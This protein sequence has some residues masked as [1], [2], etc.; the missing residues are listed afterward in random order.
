VRIAY[1]RREAI[2]AAVIG[3]A[4][5]LVIWGPVLLRPLAGF[6]P[7]DLRSLAPGR[8]PQGFL[9]QPSR[10]PARLAKS[11]PRVPIDINRADPATLQTLPGVGPTLARSIVEHRRGH[12]P[13]TAPDRLLDVEGIGP[14]RFERLKPWIEAR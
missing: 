11:A 6:A 8:P 4:L 3:L 12:G 14:K 9:A 5:A 13:F 1:T 7:V 2:V 10:A